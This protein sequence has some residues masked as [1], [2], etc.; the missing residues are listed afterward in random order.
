MQARVLGCLIEKAETTPEQYPLTVNSLRLA[1]NQ[2]TAR[3]PVVNYSEGEVGHTVRE[4]QALGF[5]KEAWGARV[6]KYEHQAGKVLGLQSKGLAVICVLMLRG[7]Q[8]LAEIKTN[9]QRLHEF[10]DLDDVAHTLGRLAEHQPPLVV[11][12]PKLPGQKESRY[13]HLLCGEPDLSKLEFRP[14]SSAANN[15]DLEER[16][17]ALEREVAELREQLEALVK[18]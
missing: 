10:G 6:A 17:E 7:P 4:L 16:V 8:T 12:L 5:V 14:T 15:S 11:H 13:A 2:K 1:C 3:F 9:S 18:N